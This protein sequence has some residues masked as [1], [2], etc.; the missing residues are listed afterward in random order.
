MSECGS[1]LFRGELQPQIKYRQMNISPLCFC[2]SLQAVLENR[3]VRGRQ[4]G[5]PANKQA[6]FPCPP[7]AI[8]TEELFFCLASQYQYCQSDMRKKTTRGFISLPVASGS[9][10][11][12][13]ARGAAPLPPG[14]VPATQ[15]SPGH[16]AR[17]AT[18]SPWETKSIAHSWKSQT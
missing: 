5:R 17:P 1:A 3:G 14:L 12:R 18:K 11:E 8:R 16:Q 13:I 10:T 6:H 2:P 15:S 7:P 4:L 9:H